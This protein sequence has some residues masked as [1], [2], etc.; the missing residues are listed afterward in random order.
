[1]W[2]V[3]SR[4]GVNDVT[5][6][7]SYTWRSVDS[8][9]STVSGS[10]TVQIDQ[11]AT[12]TNGTACVGIDSAGG[13]WSFDASDT[14]SPIQVTSSPAFSAAHVAVSNT[15][16]LVSTT[17]GDSLV[18]GSFGLGLGKSVRMTS[19]LTRVP[20]LKHCV[21]SAVSDVHS[22]VSIDVWKPPLPAL[23]RTETDP[24]SL[25][26]LCQ[27][28]IA[29]CVT[30]EVRVTRIVAVVIEI[31]LICIFVCCFDFRRF[32][33][34]CRMLPCSKPAHWLITVFRL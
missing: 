13:L 30:F 20:G 17:A 15:H 23:E 11:I 21:I 10:S 25:K 29:K 7:V 12:A 34:S 9:W 5:C 4:I 16:T 18:V 1:M 14:R 31:L 8:G 19:Q 32:P 2:L 22:T 26:A 6:Y 28:T 3:H 33:P 27:H 24:P